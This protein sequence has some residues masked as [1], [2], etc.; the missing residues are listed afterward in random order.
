MRVVGHAFPHVPQAPRHPE[1][2]QQ[3]ASAFEPN[4]QILAATL[5]PC[6]PLA[7][8]LGGDL[9]RIE[10]PR[11]AAVEDLD[12]RESSSFEHWRELAPNGLDLGTLG[13]LQTVAGAASPPATGAPRAAP[14]GARAPR[15]RARR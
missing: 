15:R 2:N 12:P 4:N 14:S 5:D 1:V 6:D 9:Q 3:S 8:E 7:L 13:H 11:Q 10:R